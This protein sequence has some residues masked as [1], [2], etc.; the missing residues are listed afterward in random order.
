MALNTFCD[1]TLHIV[2]QYCPV[3]N[4]HYVHNLWQSVRGTPNIFFLNGSISQRTVNRAFNSSYSS[5]NSVLTKNIYKFS[6]SPM[7][8][9]YPLAL[10][11]FT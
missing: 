9:N 4:Y 1:K 3:A 5:I 2:M 8:Q 6:F 11:M 10:R 7:Y